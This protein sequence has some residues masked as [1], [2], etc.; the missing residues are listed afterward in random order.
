MISVFVLM[1][2]A[3]LLPGAAIGKVAW[4]RS[5]RSN[6]SGASMDS[7]AIYEVS[8]KGRWKTISWTLSRILMT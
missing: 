8:S 3:V 1:P 5:A 7:S 6:E 4:A 2:L